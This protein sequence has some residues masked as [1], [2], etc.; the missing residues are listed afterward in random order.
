MSADSGCN[1][2]VDKRF[3]Y[4]NVFHAIYRIAVEEGILTLW[5][6]ATPSMGLFGTQTA[7]YLAKVAFGFMFFNNTPSL[8]QDKFKHYLFSIREVAILSLFSCVVSAPIDL[9]KTR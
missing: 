5:R 2:P 9:A 6:G 7:V 1:F 3:N 4:R 8:Q